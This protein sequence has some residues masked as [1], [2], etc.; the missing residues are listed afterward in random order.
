MVQQVCWY[1][2]FAP[3]AL[4]TWRRQQL[5]IKDYK[6]TFDLFGL[7]LKPSKIQTLHNPNP[8]TNP[9]ANPHPENHLEN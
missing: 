1:V 6:S 9:T 2:N 5:M 8:N 7:L 3:H 4:L